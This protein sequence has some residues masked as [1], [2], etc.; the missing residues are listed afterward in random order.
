MT[1]CGSDACCAER[2]RLSVHLREKKPPPFRLEGSAFQ[3]E[4]SRMKVAELAEKAEPFRAAARQSRNSEFRIP[5]SG[6]RNKSELRK[7][8]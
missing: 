1:T 8:D 6:R 7:M 5:N 2:L 3:P 4:R